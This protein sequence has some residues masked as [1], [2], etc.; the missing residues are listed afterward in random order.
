VRIPIDSVVVASE[1][2][3]SP[4]AIAAADYLHDGQNWAEIMRRIAQIHPDG[5][6]VLLAAGTYNLYGDLLT[7]M[8][9]Q[10]VGPTTL[11]ERH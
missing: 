5:C 7:D 8:R 11:I 4:Q 1:H 2:S 3:S 10:G 9:I 6:T